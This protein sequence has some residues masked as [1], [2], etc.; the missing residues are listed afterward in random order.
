MPANPDNR[1]CES[2][3]QAPALQLRLRRAGLL[4]GPYRPCEILD[5]DRGGLGLRG[6]GLKLRVGDK[7]NLRLHDGHSDYSA[8]GVVSYRQKRRKGVVQ[9]GVV[10]IQVPH[11]LDCLIEALMATQTNTTDKA[12][13]TP[14][15]TSGESLQL[16]PGTRRRA[17]TRYPGTAFTL[18]IRR[19]L[20][21]AAFITAQLLDIGCGGAAF[22]TTLPRLTLG[23]CIELRLSHGRSHYLVPALICSNHRPQS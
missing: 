14:A 18:R 22:T 7:V 6:R 21:G 17:D 2:R 20:P 10:F 5:I 8:A 1:R 4:G 19:P 23:K 12:A 16:I 15:P 11:E 3:L 9:Y 13:R